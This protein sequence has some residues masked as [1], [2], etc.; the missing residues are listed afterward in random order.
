MQYAKMHGLAVGRGCLQGH[1][2][3]LQ[4]ERVCQQHSSSAAIDMVHHMLFSIHS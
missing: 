1:V 4:A 3:V 2:K